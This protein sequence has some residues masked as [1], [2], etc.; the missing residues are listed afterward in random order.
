M[1]DPGWLHVEPVRV[2]P[3]GAGRNIF[4]FRLRRRDLHANV[5][6]HLFV[7]LVLHIGLP[8]LGG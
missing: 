3:R 4:A 6:G 1:H 7:D 8:L 2:D 5:V